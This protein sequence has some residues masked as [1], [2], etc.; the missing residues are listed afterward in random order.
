MY[1]KK[2]KNK[3]QIRENWWT[4]SPPPPPPPPPPSC[5]VGAK[6][7]GDP[8]WDT[9][10]NAAG[11]CCYDDENCR[12]TAKCYNPRFGSFRKCENA[13]VNSNTNTCQVPVCE[14]NRYKNKWSDELGW[15][16]YID[17]GG[18]CKDSDDCSGDLVCEGSTPGN[19][20]N[21]T[22]VHPQTE[23]NVKA[24]EEAWSNNLS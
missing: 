5:L 18:C 16:T 20:N 12:G 24:T 1:T 6:D 7:W 9:P 19:V 8:W 14:D 22:C 13:H 3:S 21:Q 17:L 11:G 4:P 2:S 15:T 10:T 23:C